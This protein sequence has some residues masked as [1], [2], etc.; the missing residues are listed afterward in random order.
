MG[1]GHRRVGD[2]IMHAPMATDDDVSIDEL[3]EAVEHPHGATARY[4]ES[5]GRPRWHGRVISKPT[6]TSFWPGQPA[7]PVDT[8]RRQV[9]TG[10]NT[11]PDSALTRLVHGPPSG[12]HRG[13]QV[14]SNRSFTAGCAI[15]TSRRPSEPCS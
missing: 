8:W 13:G 5:W 11:R 1:R 6:G 15:E 12:K 2:E 14:R 4:V 7:G 3:R 10:R 9:E